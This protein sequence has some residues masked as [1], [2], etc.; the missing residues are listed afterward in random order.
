MCD[1]WGEGERDLRTD[2]LL[3]PS[4]PVWLLAELVNLNH[5]AVEPLSLSQVLV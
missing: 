5:L 1:L 3:V 2:T 4:R